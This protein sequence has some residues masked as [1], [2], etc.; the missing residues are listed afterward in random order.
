[1]G[2]NYYIEDEGGFGA[3]IGKQSAGVSWCWADVPERPLPAALWRRYA[4]AHPEL[5]VI[6]EYGQDCGTLHAF[7]HETRRQASQFHVEG[8][9]WC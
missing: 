5:R 2:T 6:D 9:D 4:R 3:H 8:P 1:M 7:I